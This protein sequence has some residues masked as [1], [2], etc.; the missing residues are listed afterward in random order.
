LPQS[1]RLLPTPRD[2]FT[3]VVGIKAN[4]ARFAS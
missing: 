1:I 3:D 4:E 2:P